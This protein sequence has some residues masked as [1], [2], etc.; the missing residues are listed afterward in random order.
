MNVI[1]TTDGLALMSSITT[2]M[3]GLD[4]LRGNVRTARWALGMMRNELVQY[5]KNRSAYSAVD[6]A[7]LL[8]RIRTCRA[9]LRNAEATLL[10][11]QTMVALRRAR[12]AQQVALTAK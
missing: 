8:K 6:R 3:G 5:S 9:K 11:A 10:D 1:T 4:C 2:A 12:E 7:H